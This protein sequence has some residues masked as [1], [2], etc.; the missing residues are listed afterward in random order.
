MISVNQ[1]NVSMN[2]STISINVSSSIIDNYNQ[3]YS[4][5]DALYVAFY[6]AHATDN[7][8]SIVSTAAGGPW[9]FP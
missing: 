5:I 7:E 4:Y 8:A 6:H 1:S 3:L 2:T 9:P